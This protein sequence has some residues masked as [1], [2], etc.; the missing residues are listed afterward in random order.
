MARP[1]TDDL[2]NYPAQKARQGEIILKTRTQRIIFIAGLIG[3]I[4]LPSIGALIFS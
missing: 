3:M 4:A 2:Q 1:T